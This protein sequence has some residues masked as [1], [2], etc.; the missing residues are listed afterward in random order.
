MQ[1]KILIIEDNEKNRRLAGDILKFY[2]YDILEAA[3]GMTGIQMARQQS[4]DLILMDIQMPVM[5]GLAATKILKNDQETREIKILAVT[6]FAMT[7]DR[8]KILLAGADDYISKPLN[9][10]ELPR[11]VKALL[12][13]G[14]KL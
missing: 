12:E 1:K 2:G 4:P 10:R 3:D 7:G 14:P 8:E 11:K 6:S 5:D 13:A 9:T